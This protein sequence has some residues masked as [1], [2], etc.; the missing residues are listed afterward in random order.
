MKSGVEFFTC[1]TILVSD[2]QIR[3]V[4]AVAGHF[5]H[6]NKIQWQKERLDY[7]VKH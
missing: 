7:Q 6:F 5:K 3:D 2:F 1:G 4:Q